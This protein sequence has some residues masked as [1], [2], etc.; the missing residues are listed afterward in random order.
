MVGKKSPSI[1]CSSEGGVVLNGG[2]LTEGGGGQKIPSVSHSSEGCGGVKWV[3]VW[4]CQW[5][6]VAKKSPPISRSSE[7][8]VVVVPT[9]G[10][11]GEKGPSVSC[12]S[13]GG[14]WWC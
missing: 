8:G 9:E 6:V 13:E 10:R 5:R 2:V 1:S 3:V 4:W 14:V 7:R 11:G 12:S